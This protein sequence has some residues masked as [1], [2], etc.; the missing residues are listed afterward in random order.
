MNGFLML[1]SSKYDYCLF[2][3]IE[4]GMNDNHFMS[5]NFRI[6]KCRMEKYS[7]IFWGVLIDGQ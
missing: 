4:N 5:V 6:F 7:D 2:Y 1:V 3:I